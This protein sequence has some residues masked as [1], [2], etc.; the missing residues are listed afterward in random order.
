MCSSFGCRS[1]QVDVTSSVLQGSVF[2]P[3]LFSVFIS[4][5]R[6]IFPETKMYKYADD[7]TIMLEFY[8]N[9]I[10]RS[11]E[12]MDCEIGNIRNWCLCHKQTLN[13]D[14]MVSLTINPSHSL[15]IPPLT[16]VESSC[17]K[18]LGIIFDC[19]LSWTAHIT[20]L[21]KLCSQRLYVLRLLRP[22]L[23][24]D[25]LL[26]VY[27][28]FVRSIFE[29]AC[30]T[31]VSLGSI[32]NNEIEIIQKRAFRIIFGDRIPPQQLMCVS[33]RRHKLSMQFFN[34]I[35]N[36]TDH[37]LYDL[38]ASLKVNNRTNNYSFPYCNTSRRLNSFLPYMILEHNNS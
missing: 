14:K 26:S 4:S 15:I 1:T 2:G 9:S 20:G 31:F 17:L 10:D 23:T 24:D 12:I 11:L 36:N 8:K 35:K 19:N 38:V 27:Y 21:V 22:Y 29:Y 3:L 30:P 18:F 37:I 7:I 28:S 32:L 6:P 5:L 16:D 13:D 34:G 33:D 25:E